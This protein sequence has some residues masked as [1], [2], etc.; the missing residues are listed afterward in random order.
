MNTKLERKI[1]WIENQLE[2]ID[3]PTRCMRDAEG[4]GRTI[5]PNSKIKEA[6]YLYEKISEAQICLINEVKDEDE[7]YYYQQRINLCE[8]LRQGIANP[9]R[10]IICEV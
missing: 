10:C 2:K 6:R 9:V 8:E 4:Q 5:L 1:R 7:F 3:N